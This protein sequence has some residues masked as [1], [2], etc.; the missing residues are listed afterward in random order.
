MI[1]P[2]VQMR[3][4]KLT[5]RNLAKVPLKTGNQAPKPARLTNI[6]IYIEGR[7]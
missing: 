1:I 4:E 5:L 6:L 2:T 3:K 7:K